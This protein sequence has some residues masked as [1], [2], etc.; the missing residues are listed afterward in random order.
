[1]HVISRKKEKKKRQYESVPTKSS[2][3]K[4]KFNQGQKKKTELQLH[5]GPHVWITNENKNCNHLSGKKTKNP[6]EDR[7]TSSSIRPPRIDWT[8]RLAFFSVT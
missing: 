7:K 1:M 8:T 6:L 2:C 5:E 4:G 3:F